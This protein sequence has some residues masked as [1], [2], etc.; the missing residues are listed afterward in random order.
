MPRSQF[1]QEL[2]KMHVDLDRM[3]HLVVLAIENCVTAFKEQDYELARDIIHGDKQINDVER[4]I[5]AKCLSLILKQQ[6]VA[7]DLRD[8]STALKVVTDLER[9]GDQSADI[10]ELILEMKEMD[11]FLMIG[12]IQ[13][14][15]KIATKMV[16]EALDAFHQHDLNHA[17]EVKKMDIKMDELFDQVKE[18]II[19]M[20]KESNDK[21][22]L[23]INFLMIAKYFER[24]GDHAVNIAEWVQFFIT[25][26]HKRL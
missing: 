10:A 2:N 19:Q 20:I 24:I 26:E 13:D 14:M 1:D 4:S 17:L 25:G 8:V 11:S 7:S 3:C 5:E 18:D 15:A 16:K 22:D 23:T 12:H 9:I 21:G 6:P